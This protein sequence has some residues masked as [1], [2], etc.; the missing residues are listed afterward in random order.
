MNFFPLQFSCA[1]AL[2]SGGVIGMSLAVSCSLGAPVFSLAPSA[3]CSALG[4]AHMRLHVSLLQEHAAAGGRRPALLSAVGARTDC[5]VKLRVGE[6]WVTPPHPQMFIALLLLHCSW[7]N[8]CRT[9]RQGVSHLA[10]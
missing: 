6:L 2:Q 8:T 9:D 4:G 1:P 10:H 7:E 5:S 3:A